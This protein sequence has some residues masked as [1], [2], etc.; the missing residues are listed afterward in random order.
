MAAISSAGI[1]SGLDV[2][3]II[4][5]LMAI[6]QQPKDKLAAD[7][8]KIQTQI[9]EVGKVTSAL[10]TLRDVSYKLSSSSFWNQT[11]ATSSSSNITVTSDTTALAG[12]Y[13]VAVQQLAGSQAVMGGTTF[14]SS[15]ALVGSGTMTI[16]M[17][18]WGTGQTSFTASSTSPS[19]AS[20]TVAA[21][22]TVETLRDKI[23][24]AG[25]G[26]S[27]SILSDSTGARLVMRSSSTGAANAFRVTT[28]GASGG[29][30]NMGY[31]PSSGINSATRTQTA[32]NATATI[33]GVSVS[34]ASNTFTNVMSGVSFTANALTSS[35]NTTTNTVFGVPTTSS[36]VTS[37]P[38]TLTVATDTASIKTKL[39]EFATAYTALNS[40][41]ATDTKYDATTKK[42]GPLQ[43]DSSIVGIQTRMRKLL[44]ATSTASTTYA[45]LSD[46]GLELQRDG[47]LTLN[48]TKVD[49]ALSNFSQMKALFV[50]NPTTS[51]SAEGFGK[52]FYDSIY[53]MTT[54]GGSV[55][56][57]STAL[58]DK[59][60]RNQKSQDAM[61]A[62]LAQTQKALEAQYG[63]LD[64]RMASFNGLSSYVNQQVTQWNK[65]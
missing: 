49:S 44:A 13:S 36:T 4:S 3:S 38:V 47:S 50:D 8:T 22:D 20:I 64:S 58:S 57:R 59:L 65:A 39:Q 46:A 42:A 30:A 63:A 32:S 45:R 37:S 53:S 9:S 61:T 1:G 19:S 29:V 17:G 55:N 14:A 23:N 10:S 51:A 26:V 16:Q 60:A 21:T 15:T 25:I 33:D 18:T 31:D 52:Q 40:L 35:T 43:G 62:R 48:S 34:S 5:Q 56:A 27:A 11:T 7:A 2:K 6:E 12:Q 54:L 41:V 28:S 24:A